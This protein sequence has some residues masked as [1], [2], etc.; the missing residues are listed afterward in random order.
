MWQIDSNLIRIM[1]LLNKIL[2]YAINLLCSMPST[3]TSSDIDENTII[4]TEDKFVVGKTFDC[5][6]CFIF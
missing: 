2:A 6:L 1:S 4:N 5:E 3:L